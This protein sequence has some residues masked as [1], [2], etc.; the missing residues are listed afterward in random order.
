MEEQ[1]SQKQQ[2][3]SR[4]KEELKISNSSTDPGSISKG[5]RRWKLS[6]LL[7]FRN[8]SEGSGSSKD[9]LKKYFVG[10]MKN[11]S[12]E[13][14]G[15]SF[16]SSDSFSKHGSTSSFR[17]RRCARPL[18]SDSERLLMRTQTTGEF[19]RTSDPVTET[20]DPVVVDGGGTVVQGER[21]V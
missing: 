3:P 20:V 18:Q 11:T 12:E 19:T 21:V 6:D 17:G 10:Y 7:L 2:Q 4:N 13:V 16:R 14:K 15:S 8:S 5:S 9:P 1:N